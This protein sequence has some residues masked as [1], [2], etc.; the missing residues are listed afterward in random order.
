M[1]IYSM[2]G[3]WFFCRPTLSCADCARRMRLL[4]DLIGS[5][6]MFNTVDFNRENVPCSAD[7]LY[8]V[9]RG[10]MSS[11]CLCI[12]STTQFHAG[13]GCSHR[14]NI[15]GPS[16]RFQSP[17]RWFDTREMACDGKRLCRWVLCF[18]CF[19]LP[20]SHSNESSH[21]LDM[22]NRLWRR[23]SRTICRDM[24]TMLE[25]VM[26]TV[27]HISRCGLWY[28]T[29]TNANA[30]MPTESHVCSPFITRPTYHDDWWFQMEMQRWSKVFKL[31]IES[32][33]CHLL[34]THVYICVSVSSACGGRGGLMIHV[35]AL[36]ILP[37]R[38][39]LQDVPKLIWRS[40]QTLSNQWCS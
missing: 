13:G 27:C 31:V 39:F 9:L 11:S 2:I 33:T 36:T 20:H 35:E 32:L 8:N 12:A 16:S 30:L 17:I 25:D 14:R 26:G 10:L 1:L 18:A 40:I 7:V 34:D 19:F 4:T 29:P 3:H 15:L 24:N 37:S 5:F 23:V 38:R 21:A 22:E 6:K 28:H